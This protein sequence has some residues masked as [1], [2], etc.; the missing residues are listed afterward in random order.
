[1]TGHTGTEDLHGMEH[2]S[3]ELKKLGT[4]GFLR[5]QVRSLDILPGFRKSRGSQMVLE[6]VMLPRIPEPM[7]LYH[8]L[9]N[10]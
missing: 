3:A 10:F 2:L 5:L 4:N 7:E 8:K 6:K 9:T 1:M